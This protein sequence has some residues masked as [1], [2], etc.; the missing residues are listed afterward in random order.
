VP[1]TSRPP[2]RSKPIVSVELRA[3]FKADRDTIAK[4]R[5]AYPGAKASR[6]SIEI[7]LRGDTPGETSASARKLL[8]EIRKAGLSSK[9]FK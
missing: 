7:V 3:T 1:S 6:G 9:E 5:K 4:L 2:S 8:E